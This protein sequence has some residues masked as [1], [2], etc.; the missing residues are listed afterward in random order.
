MSLKLL[1]VVEDQRRMKLSKFLNEVEESPYE[2]QQD[3]QGHFRIYRH[4]ANGTVTT[5]GQIKFE[6]R[7]IKPQM[8]TYQNLEKQ[9]GE[10]R[11]YLGTWWPGATLELQAFKDG[12]HKVGQYNLPEVLEDESEDYGCIDGVSDLSGYSPGG[13]LQ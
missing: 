13:I 11:T 10:V 4:N 1:D 7:Q 12:D 8:T 3:N 2:V 6:R 5:D 9:T